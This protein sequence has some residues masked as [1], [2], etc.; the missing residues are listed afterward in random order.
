MLPAV[1]TLIERFS[2]VFLSGE[3]G[4]VATADGGVAQTATIELVL[5]VRDAVNELWTAHEVEIKRCCAPFMPQ[6][7][8]AKQEVFGFALAD[9]LGRPIL[10]G[11][12]AMKVGQNGDNAVRW[13]EGSKDRT[14]KLTAARE[15]AR[16]A[17]RKARRAADKDAALEPGEVRAR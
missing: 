1:A 16:A 4:P 13:A 9:A 3:D 8:I 5:A 7:L 2:I 10:P 15:T 14:G 11:D 12:K 17:V 6:G